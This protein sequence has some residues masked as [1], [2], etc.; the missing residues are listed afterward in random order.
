MDKNQ[1]NPRPMAG[2]RITNREIYDATIDIKDRVG[3]LE[4]RLNTALNQQEQMQEDVRRLELRFYGLLAGIITAI[5]GTI[6]A[7]LNSGITG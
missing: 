5:G 6:M 7:L 4:N 3:K 2:I 1:P